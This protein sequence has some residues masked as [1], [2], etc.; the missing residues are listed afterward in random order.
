MAPGC[1]KA[2]GVGRVDALGHL[3]RE[4]E[5]G[6]ARIHCSEPGSAI[7]IIVRVDLCVWAEIITQHLN[8]FHILVTKGMGNGK[9]NPA[10]Y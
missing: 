4:K 3:E 9:I 10:C 2:V 5:S 1:R 8:E 6:S 7:L